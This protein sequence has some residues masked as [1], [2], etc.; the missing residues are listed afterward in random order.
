MSLSDQNHPL[1]LS[2][3][4]AA[5]LQNGKKIPIDTSY[6]FNINELYSPK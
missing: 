3:Y 5:K 6:R 2:R 4:S 1:L